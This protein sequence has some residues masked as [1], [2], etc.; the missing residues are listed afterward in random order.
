LL[1]FLGGTLLVLNSLLGCGGVGFL[2]FVSIYSPAMRD[3]AIIAGAGF[4]KK[5]TRAFP[6]AFF[7]FSPAAF[8]PPILNCDSHSISGTEYGCGKKKMEWISST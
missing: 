6:A 1:I 4:K 5:H 3:V 7:E 8:L 2:C